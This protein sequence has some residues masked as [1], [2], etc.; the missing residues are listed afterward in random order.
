M[1]LPKCSAGRRR[2]ALSA[3]AVSATMM[4]AS[5][6]SASRFAEVPPPA[7]PALD[8]EAATPCRDPGVNRNPKVAVVEHREALAECE[9][10]REVAATSYNRVRD[11]FG[12][13]P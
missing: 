7:I 6:A 10:K 3:L 4:L 5:C 2:A 8:S 1:T 13:L 12:V 9:G 11:A